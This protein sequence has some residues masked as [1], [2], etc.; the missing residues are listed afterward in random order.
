M[1]NTTMV[2]T[3]IP[4]VYFS[5]DA[6]YDLPNL[7]WGNHINSLLED[8]GSEFV[9]E[10]LRHPKKLT[11]KLLLTESD[12]SKL[13]FFRPKYL[14]RERS[15]FYLNKVIENGINTPTCELIRL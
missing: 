11:K 6:P 9:N 4:L 12:I 7:S 14:S 8:Y 2:T 15:Y 3:D 5:L 1:Y 10:M 13:N